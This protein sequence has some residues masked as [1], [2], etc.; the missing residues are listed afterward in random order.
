MTVLLTGHDLARDQVVRVARD[1]EPVSLDPGARAAMDR[2]HAIVLA[3]IRGG[4]PIYGTT[5]G[6]GALK[7]VGMAPAEAAG[8][9]SWML[10][11]HLVGQGPLAPPDVVRATIL[12]LANHFAEG[13]P[14]VRPA[15]VDRLIDALNGGG[16]PA[17]HAIGS[18]GQADL[19]PLAE[20]AV[21]IIGDLELEPGEGTALLDSNAFST[22]WAALAIA[23]TVALLDAM[24]VAGAVSLDGFAANPTMI[25]P[26]IGAVRPYPGIRATLERLAELLDGSAIHEPG[27]PRNLQDPLSF[28]NLPQVQGA[29]RDAVAHVAAVLAIELNANQGNPIVV[30][31]EDGVISVANF[32][33]LPLAAALD[34]LRVVLATAL[35]VATER[36]VKGLYTPWSGLP[37]GLAPDGDTAHA[38]LT[39][40]SLAA[41]SLAVEARLLAAP[42]SFELT[43][44]SHAEGIE[45]RTTMAPLAARRL[46]EMVELGS[47]VVAIEL[48]VGAQA[49]ELRGQRAGAGTARAV[50]AVRRH[51]PFLS[52]DVQVP[53]VR[54]L[55]GAVRAGEITR[56]AFGVDGGGDD[57]GGGGAIDAGSRGIGDVDGA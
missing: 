19:A 6:V 25:H 3:S 8:Y 22:A 43:S 15:L 23:D 7:R 49:V 41:Q 52:M 20:L 45:D 11:H 46:A 18:V 57:G 50:A 27:V 55:A 4:S 21:A 42:V 34:Y 12:R 31:A 33:I 37:T 9:S 24:D 38:G 39:Y 1:G 29:C 26:V 51:V 16:A 44:T 28:R 54:G 13:S 14:G 56:A 48:A 32:E 17:V 5:T 36:I 30:P 10:A 35:G 47:T 40:L 53:D 2:T